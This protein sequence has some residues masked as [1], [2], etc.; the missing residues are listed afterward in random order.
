MNTSELVPVVIAT[1]ESRRKVMRKQ[2]DLKEGSLV[3][4]EE[5]RE[6]RVRG[7]RSSEGGGKDNERR[8]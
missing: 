6:E 1:V 2:P 4:A 5:G 8:E 7:R 3:K